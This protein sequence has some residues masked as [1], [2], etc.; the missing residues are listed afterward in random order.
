MAASQDQPRQHDTVVLPGSDAWHDTAVLQPPPRSAVPAGWYGDPFGAPG[1]RYWDGH[2]WTSLTSGGR[3][4]DRRRRSVPLSLLLAFLF[5]GMALPYA[6]PLPTWARLLIVAG[7]VWA[8]NWWLL[9]LVPLSWP[10][11]MVVVP[12]LTYA[13]NPR[14]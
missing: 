10:F 2:D 11:A 1:L 7:L 5:G 13:L 12:L 3:G 6:L 4:P 9:L 14:R 8:L